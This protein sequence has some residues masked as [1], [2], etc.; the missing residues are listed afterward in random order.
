M[1]GNTITGKPVIQEFGKKGATY[2]LTKASQLEH[3]KIYFE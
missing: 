2:S 3:L 1:K